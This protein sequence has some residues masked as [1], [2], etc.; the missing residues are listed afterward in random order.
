MY[1]SIWAVVEQGNIRPLENIE[2]PEG[3]RVLV[4]FMPETESEF[5]IHAS[6]PSLDEIWNNSDDDVYAELL[7]K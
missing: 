5:W 3:T 6:Q 2:A 1:N 4:T 7:Q